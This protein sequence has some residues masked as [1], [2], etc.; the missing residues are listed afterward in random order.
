[1]EYLSVTDIKFSLETAVYVDKLLPR[2]GVARYKTCMPEI[3]YT[4]QEVACMERRPLK[5]TPTQEQVSI[6]EMVNFEWLPL[7]EHNERIL[8]W[9]RA[10]FI[11]WK[12]LC[13][14]F[15]LS[16]ATLAKS[17]NTALVKIF[18]YEKTKK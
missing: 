4:P 11:P 8:L 16:R 2:V 13:R 9:K 7:L 5:L 14:E 6:W 3:V 15:G 17:Y 10:S 18:I 1:M 12:L